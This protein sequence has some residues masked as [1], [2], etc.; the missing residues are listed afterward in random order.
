MAA[1]YWYV[2]NNGSADWSVA[3]NWYLGPGG[4]VGPTGL[5]TT[6]DT[7]Y[8]DQASGSGTLSINAAASCNGLICTGFTGALA[9]VSTLT[10]TDTTSSDPLGQLLVFSPTMSIT[11]SGTFTINGSGDGNS[12]TFGG[13]TFPG[14]ITLA[15][16]ATTGST[17][18]NFLDTARITGLLTI[19]SGFI[20][21]TS[22]LFTG[23]F[24]MSGTGSSTNRDIFGGTIYLTGSGAVLT[25]S[26]TGT[27]SGNLLYEL[28]DTSANTKTVVSTVTTA[29]GFEPNITITG[30][31]T[32]SY[33]L[34]GNFANINVN[35]SGGATFSFG[36]SNIWSLSF[37]TS[38][39]N[40]NNAAIALAIRDSLFLSSNM[41]VTASPT[42]TFN[43]N[44]SQISVTCN[45]KQLTRA[46]TVAGGSTLSPNDDFRLSNSL[47]LTNGSISSNSDVYVNSISSSSSNFR[48]IIINANLYLTG[49]GTLVTTT[50]STNLSVSIN[51]IYIQDTSNTGLAK[52]LTFNAVFGSP[53]VYIA[54]TG[55]GLITLAAAN[56][57]LP[58][59]YVTNTGGTVSFTSGTIGNLEFVNGTTC[60]WSNA[61]TQTLNIVNN[62]KFAVGQPL[63]TVTP[64]MIF[65]Q[66]ASIITMNGNRLV[67]GAL[68]AG[69]SSGKTTFVDN[70]TTN[71]AVSI[72]DPYTDSAAEGNF[73]CSTLT[74]NGSGV[75]NF[76]KNI[77]A[78][79]TTISG[80]TGVS[81]AGLISPG[82][83]FQSDVNITTLTV[84]SA[85]S[86][87]L[88]INGGTFTCTSIS[89]T[90]AYPITIS[91]GTTLNCSSISLTVGSSLNV[92]GNS[93]IN[94][95][96]AFSTA[97]GSVDFNNT[98]ATFLTFGISG[99]TSNYNVNN[100]K[101]YITG[102]TGTAFSLAST[103]ASYTSDRTIIEF[104]NTA[105]TNTTFAGGGFTYHELIFNRGTSANNNV[106]T[107]NNTFTNFRDFGTAGHFITFPSGGIQTIGH[108]DVQGSP[109]NV[110]SISRAGTSGVSTLSKSPAGLVICDYVAVTNIT[111][112]ET[113]TF[114][115][116]PNSTLTNAANWIAGGKVRNQSALGVG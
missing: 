21:F 8:L 77:T 73:T 16:S 22:Q 44:G 81:I 68:T 10:I 2:A 75:F 20:F 47:T 105:N 64:A 115:S 113:N 35:N 57:F 7:V 91:G 95:T 107:G 24:S 29:S 48:D 109:G 40:W 55:A 50:T 106:I 3:G 97:A 25:V 41:T 34:T 66:G 101:I 54:G 69:Y 116:G 111:A 72:T 84:S 37:N 88:T 42:I 78:T 112:N 45:T 100:S 43:A 39:V 1:K 60:T 23:R 9:G 28:T 59:V 30:S 26:T 110:I 71:A 102:A 38:N 14:N 67:T 65:N 18:V 108:F 80:S 104:T 114:Y 90:S 63:S 83:Y 96:G 99:V 61:A 103:I 15:K 46:I 51:A 4:T 33:S 19:S 31:G 94:C 98:T 27:Y 36:A 56:A 62:L 5:P 86:E 70:F 76:K 79:V 92:D 6:S 85:N 11:Y 74:I 87:P 58:Y 49:T 32:G 53:T 93:I 82:V 89:N 17:Q 52:T 12:I 13:Q